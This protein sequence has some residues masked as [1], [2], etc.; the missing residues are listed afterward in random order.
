M[1][2]TLLYSGLF[3]LLGTTVIAVIVVLTG[4]SPLVVHV[5][6]SAATATPGLSQCHRERCRST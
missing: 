2:L 5:S 3:L 4:H 6:G 1:R